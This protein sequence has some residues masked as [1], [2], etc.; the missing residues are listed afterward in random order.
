MTSEFYSLGYNI[1]HACHSPNTATRIPLQATCGSLHVPWRDPGRACSERAENLR[2]DRQGGP[3]QGYRSRRH[4]QNLTKYTKLD[5]KKIRSWKNFQ[6]KADAIV[7]SSFEEVLY[8]D[9]DNIPLRD[10]TYLFD[11][12]LYKG[13]GQPEVVF[14]PDLNKDHRKPYRTPIFLLYP[15]MLMDCICDGDISQQSYLEANRENMRR[16]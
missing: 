13:P 11:T 9:S 1:P 8:L 15:D 7:Q 14:W 2:C 5:R 12:T 6:I 3:S 16:E 10:P 4:R